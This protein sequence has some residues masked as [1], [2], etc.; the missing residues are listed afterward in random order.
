MVVGT[1]G[2]SRVAQ[3]FDKSPRSPWPH[4]GVPSPRPLPTPPTRH[5]AQPPPP[6]L[7][8]TGLLAN[9]CYCAA[10]GGQMMNAGRMVRIRGL[11]NIPEW[12]GKWADDD[13]SW[14]N[15]LRQLMAFSKDDN[16]GTFWMV[17]RSGART[18]DSQISARIC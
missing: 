6:D 15:Q 7:E 2:G 13:P 14:T 4:T 12:T 10:T 17:G 11:A 16:D 9:V 3:L 18:P 5:R 1:R 8:A